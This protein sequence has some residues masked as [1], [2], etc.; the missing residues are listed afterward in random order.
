MSQ[1]AIEA[2]NLV[3]RFAR[4]AAPSDLQ[5]EPVD[6]EEPAKTPAPKRSRWPFGR[7]SET[8]GFTAVDG[9]SLQIDRGEVFGLLGPNGAGKSTTI[10]MVCTLLEPTSGTA[11]VNGFD[12]IKQSNQVRQSLG[13]V[14]AGERSI[15]WK[16]TARENLEYFAALYHLPPAV[17]HQRIDELL[18]Q[19]ELTARANDLVEKYSTGMKQRVAIARSLLARPPILLFDEP[20]LG[21]DPQ[22]ARRVRELVTELKA[23]GH[24]ILL[25]THYMEEADQL[26][27]RIGI[28]DQGK[29]IALDTPAAL[30]RRIDQKDVIKLEVAQWHSEMTAAL[31]ALPNVDNLLARHTGSDSV[32]EVSLHASNSRAILPRIIE[33]VSTNGTRLLNMNI[34]QP[35]LEDV[36]IHLTGKALRD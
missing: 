15:Y 35:T 7:R 13:T 31:Q 11:H 9:V 21:L 19:M 29:V 34:V 12:I 27:D 22:A 25:T 18:D 8:N 4:R 33:T 28:I 10:R 20:T 6:G 14:L 23:K 30:K 16:L 24:T 32:Y 2:E 17:A 5:A 36:F 1:Y 26:S 3:K